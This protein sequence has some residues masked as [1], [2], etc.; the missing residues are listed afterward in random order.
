[1]PRDR[2][3]VAY[4][5]PLVSLK[6]DKIRELY[7][8]LI[9]LTDGVEGALRRLKAAKEVIAD[10]GL[11]TEC[12]FGRRPPETILALLELHREVAQTAIP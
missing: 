2:S 8:G 10:F 7:V 12:G 11:A 9:H 4:F 6:R 1:V 5:R 3:D